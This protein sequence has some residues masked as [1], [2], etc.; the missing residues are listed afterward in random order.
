MILDYCCRC[1]SVTLIKRHA[2]HLPFNTKLNDTW[3]VVQNLLMCVVTF[4]AL[5]YVTVSLCIGILR[6]HEVDSML[7]PFDYITQPS[8][9]D[10]KYL[11]C[12]ISM[13]V[14]YILGGVAFAYIVEEWVWDYAI[15]VTLLHVMLT[16]AVM[17]DIPSTEHWWMALGSG[18]VMMIAGGQIVAA[19][20]FRSNFVYPADLQNF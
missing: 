19:K 18:L 17:S 8:W 2:Q 20:V 11:V 15:T 3:V 5:Y 12:V 13:E 16:V 4:Y 6:V 10:P 14:T 7:A 1:C 9:K